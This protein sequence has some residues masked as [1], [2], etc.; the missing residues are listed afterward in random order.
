MM[1]RNLKILMAAFLFA[2]APISSP[3]WASSS[4]VMTT[5]PYTEEVDGVPFSFGN[6]NL[7]HKASSPRKKN[8]VTNDF[9]GNGSACTVGKIKLPQFETLEIYS[10]AKGE[11]DGNDLIT[12]LYNH[13]G[14]QSC[15]FTFVALPKPDNEWSIEI[16][17]EASHRCKATPSSGRM[18]PI[19]YRMDTRPPQYF[20]E[21]IGRWGSNTNAAAHFMGDSL[22]GA[23]SG[24]IDSAFISFAD[25]YNAYMHYIYDTA[26]GN[27]LMDKDV[28]IYRI[29]ADNAFFKLQP[30]LRGRFKSY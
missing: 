21:G 19:L 16:S 10:A 17:G 25:D 6:V 24:E 29:R 15:T 4:L 20:V 8:C 5:G 18:V 11:R 2:L 13:R 22:Q 9:S 14:E 3:V 1:N 27:E 26:I 28:W 30:V 12:T 7:L 23:Q